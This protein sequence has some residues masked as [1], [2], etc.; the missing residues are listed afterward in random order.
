MSAKYHWPAPLRSKRSEVLVPEA[1]DWYLRQAM[2][3]WFEHGRDRGSP[4]HR[5]LS[6]KVPKLLMFF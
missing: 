4:S 3:P 6:E 5:M 2:I 1:Y